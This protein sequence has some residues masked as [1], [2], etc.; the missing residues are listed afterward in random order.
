M[1]GV[2]R[3][4]FR[5]TPPSP[6]FANYVKFLFNQGLDSRCRRAIH[7]FS[8]HRTL[9]LV[10]ADARFITVVGDWVFDSWRGC[11]LRTSNFRQG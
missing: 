1:L 11:G 4:Y 6:D 2:A 7:K 3:R 9:L 8:V 5:S 10:K